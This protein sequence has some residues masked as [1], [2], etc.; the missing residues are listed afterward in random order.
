LA[1][2]TATST[3]YSSFVD[4]VRF[5]VNTLGDLVHGALAQ[6]VPLQVATTHPMKYLL[7]VPEQGSGSSSSVRPRA[8]VIAIDGADRNFRGYHA[9]FV[10]A[11]RS[12]PFAVVT[13]FV[14]SN[15]GRPNR[16]RYPYT[17]DVWSTAQ[18]DR[19]I[20]DVSGI[21]AIIRDMHE[22]FGEA[23]P[24]FLTAFSAGGHLAWLLLLTHPDW[25]AG[26][27]LASANFTGRGLS[28][29]QTDTSVKFVPVHAF[30]GDK[31]RRLLV[32]RYQW[33]LARTIAR[34]C[35]FRELARTMVRGAGHS[36]FSREVLSYFAE[37][38]RAP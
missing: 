18:S 23:L 29:T 5:V 21:A 1:G 35:G 3:L 34:Q 30:F 12:L 4:R 16:S 13:P 6:R 24:V 11:R 26:V 2:P 10:R 31:D 33:T 17:T 15:G 20:F 32:L 28:G 36:P 27:A 25:F 38:M 9:A 37:V 22:R 7:T 14:L 19:L 8:L